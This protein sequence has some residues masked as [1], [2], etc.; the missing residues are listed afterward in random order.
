[1]NKNS[2]KGMNNEIEDV[3]ICVVCGSRVIE[4]KDGDAYCTG[5]GEKVK[6]VDDDN[7]E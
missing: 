3:G 1:M 4:D 6:E 2:V 5:C 7:E